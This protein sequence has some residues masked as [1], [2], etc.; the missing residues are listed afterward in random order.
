MK[1]LPA[2]AVSFSTCSSVGRPDAVGAEAAWDSTALF[3]LCVSGS[4]SA[5]SLSSALSLAVTTGLH[6]ATD[7]YV[8]ECS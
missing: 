6:K 7:R 3:S 8:L 2:A 4:L 5:D 1:A